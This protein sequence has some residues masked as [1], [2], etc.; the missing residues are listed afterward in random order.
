[1]RPAA[2]ICVTVLFEPRVSN[3]SRGVTEPVAESAG[4]IRTVGKAAGIRDLA[5]RLA[6]AQQ[7]PAMQKLRGMIQTTDSMK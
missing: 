3:G 7:L 5:Q 4:E 6:C 2:I 1:L